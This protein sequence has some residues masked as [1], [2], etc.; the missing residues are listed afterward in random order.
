[1][2]RAAAKGRQLPGGQT[3]SAN[4]RTGDSE[5]EERQVDDE[6]DSG[7]ANEVG[8]KLAGD[9]ATPS[10]AP[11]PIAGL[12]SLI[13]MFSVSGNKSRGGG[14]T[15]DSSEHQQQQPRGM[16]RSRSTE[17]GITAKGPWKAIANVDKF[18]AVSHDGPWCTA[19]SGDPLVKRMGNRHEN[20][21]CHPPHGFQG[22]S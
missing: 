3:S 8:N 4:Q 7:A 16:P 15:D 1:M 21:T 17:G 11:R 20:T 10:S 9:S 12:S 19:R 18:L 2:V 13:Q 22:V 5:A 6:G 14:N